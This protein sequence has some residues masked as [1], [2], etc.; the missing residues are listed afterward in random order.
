MTNPGFKYSAN[1]QNDY[2]DGHKKSAYFF[3]RYE[4]A[5]QYLIILERRIQTLYVS[6]W[7]NI[8]EVLVRFCTNG[9]SKQQSRMMMMMPF[10]LVEPAS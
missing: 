3:H 10:E 8:V 1:K 5:T 2:V 6:Q 4:L 9:F 7:L